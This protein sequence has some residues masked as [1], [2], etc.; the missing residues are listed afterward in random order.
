M[1]LTGR[2]I[3]ACEL[4][5]TGEAGREAVSPIT[6][7]PLPVRFLDA[8]SEEVS[9]AAEAAAD[10]FRAYRSTPPGVRARFLRA[11][12]DGIEDLGGELIERCH[13]ETGLPEARLT[14]ER[15]RTCNQ[16][17]LFADVLEEG[18][19]VDARITTALPERT[20]APRPDLRRML[21]ALG[22]VVVFGASNFPLAFSVAGGDTASALA[23]GCPVIVKAHSSHPGT[24]ELV[25]RAV[26]G[27]ATATGMPAG[28]FSVLHGPGRTVGMQLVQHEA[29]QAVGFTG[30]YAGGRAL[31]DAAASRPHPIPVYAEMGSINPV[32]VLP[33]AAAERTEEIAAG[34][35]GSVTLG[36]GQFCTNPG[37]VAG[38][39]GE[40]FSSLAE[41]TGRRISGVEAGVMLNR[42]IQS[43]YSDGIA[44]LQ[45]NGAVEQLAL[46]PDG[47]GP[48]SYGRS[49]LFQTKA[50]ALLRDRSLS[51][52]VFGP[53][54]VLV[55]AESRE[56]LMELAEGLVGHLT[57]TLHATPADLREYADLVTVLQEKSG[58]LILNGYPTGVEVSHAMT[59]GGPFPSTTDPHFTSV[60][61]AAILRFVRP[62]TWQGFPDSALPDELRNGNPLGIMRLVDGEL[63]RE[64][65]A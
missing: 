53:A 2:Q 52:E 64:P 15:A 41:A 58:R 48:G 26:A 19:W 18:S 27:A 62:F 7:E 45:K 21:V 22:P 51:E 65:L 11:A 56:E 31:F 61:T 39:A 3:I 13:L 54:T 35:T 60:G 55:A 34:L 59:H 1:T 8:T 4:A 42:R 6:N 33:G 20:P 16:L 28:V 25:G 36:V 30:S 44:N 5:G 38:L 57:C 10:A 47:S 23:A 12:A 17:R 37:L 14:G 9:A 50:S 40:S 49:A 43:A 29:V 46:G 63:T 32:F 24:S